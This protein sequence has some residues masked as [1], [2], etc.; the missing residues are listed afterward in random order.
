VS[1]LKAFEY[2]E[3]IGGYRKLEEIEHE[4]VEYALEKFERLEEGL[5]LHTS[6]LNSFS[7]EEKEATT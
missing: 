5:S 3:H 1:L 2:I 4:L 7:C 6:I